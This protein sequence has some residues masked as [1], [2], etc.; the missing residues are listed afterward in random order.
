MFGIFP[1]LLFLALLRQYGG[2]LYF[3]STDIITTDYNR[4]WTD[5][6]ERYDCI[7]PSVIVLHSTS[8]LVAMWKHVNGK[9]VKALA[10]FTVSGTRSS[11]F[12]GFCGGCFDVAYLRACLQ[13]KPNLT[14]FVQGGMYACDELDPLKRT[15]SRGV[16]VARAFSVS[17]SASAMSWSFSRL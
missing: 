15:Q 12:L 3:P 11:D 13:V 5:G 2:T 14:A 17:V 10:K 4:L 7:D 16:V 9:Y 6:D 8:K 1:F